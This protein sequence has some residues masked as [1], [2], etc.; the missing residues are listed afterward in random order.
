MFRLSSA[1]LRLLGRG[2]LILY[3]ALA[4][5]ILA[6]RYWALPHIDD[7]R[8]RIASQISTL[9]DINVS[10][11]PMQ[12]E[13]KG[14]NPS[15]AL[16][17][18][19]LT[20]HKGR[21]LLALPQV[22]AVL[23]WR[24]LFALSPL[25]LSLDAKGADLSL[26]RDRG[27]GYWLMGQ[28]VDVQAGREAKT[29]SSDTFIRWLAAQRNIV[30]RDAVLRWNDEM[31]GAPPLVLEGVTL[32]L[33]SEGSEHRLA[34]AAAPPPRLGDALDVRGTF[35]LSAD[36][37]GHYSLDAVDGQLYTHVENLRPL[38]WAPWF[39]LP[40]DLK[41]GR[42]SMQTWLRVEH[43]RVSHLTSDLRVDRGRWVVG[44]DTQIRARSLHLYLDGS[45][46]GY[47]Q[48]FP[49]PAGQGEADSSA[50]RT[51]AGLDY[52]LLA[53]GL[54]VDAP[55]LFDYPLAFDLIWA[56]GAVNKTSGAA[57]QL[58]ADRLQLVN[59]DMDATL[60]GTWREGGSG[61][62]GLI[63]LSGRF[64]RAMITAIDEYLPTTVNLDAREWMAKGLLDGEITDAD[65]VLQGDL[66][67]FPFA[68]QPSEGD[69]KVVGR[70]SGGVIDYLPPEGK[71]LGWPRLTDMR[72][73]VSLHRAD[74]RL[75]AEQASMW[76]ASGL[77][78]ELKDVHARIPNIEHDSV[79]TIQGQTTAK[80]QAY[81]A[82]MTHSPLGQMLDGAFDEARADG[83]WEV[84]LELSIPLLHS[85]D[86]TV[87]GSIHLSG[88]ALRLM[89]EMPVF[90]KVTGSLEFTDTA[91]STSALQAEFLG[92]P[93]TLGGGIGGAY[94]GLQFD[95]RAA[96]KALEAYAGVEGMRRLQG[97]VPY[98]ALLQRGKADALTI[99][100]TS[101]LQGL[102]VNLP[103]PLGK[104]AQQTLPLK[105]DWRPGDGGNMVLDIALGDETRATL[106]RREGRS[107]GP[108]FHAGSLGIGKRPA[109]LDSGLRLDI[110]YP[111]IDLDAWDTAITEFSTP[112]TQAGRD[113]AQQPERPLLPDVGELR[114]QAKQARV[115]G[116]SLDELTFTARR[117]Q[118]AQ[119]R[120]DI[121]SS[122]TAGTLIWREANGRVAGHVDAVFDRLS[123]GSET[124]D[125]QNEGDEG[126]HVD[127]DLDFPAVNLHVKNF[128][129]Y[130]RH[131]GEL[132][133]VGVNQERGRL[134]RLDELKL[135]SPHA[136]LAGSGL[137]RLRGAQRG[138]TLDAQATIG[139][140]GAYLEQIGFKDLA[141]QGK[142]TLQGHFEWRNM[143]WE[144]SK[145][146][147]NGKMEFKLEKGRLSTLNSQ[148]ARLLE[149]LSLQ[150]V[151]RLARL[152]FNPAGLT[153]EGFPYDILRGALKFEDG[154]MSTDDYRVIGPVGTIVLGGNVDLMKDTLDLRAVVI[155]NLDVSGAAIAAGIAINPIVGLGA[156]LTQWLLQAPLAKAMTVEYRI[157]GPW[158][159]PQ[160]QELATPARTGGSR[161]RS[162]SAPPVEH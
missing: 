128:R 135:V 112:L 150:S 40:Q 2:A 13:W 102:A 136:S 121:S 66:E 131:V 24:S 48:L 138:L 83:A 69:F 137:W 108:Y 38:G 54:N 157:S 105:V 46:A 74:L 143:P 119:W 17:D 11:G 126:L 10:L 59:K 20:D 56:Q 145:R 95:G 1:C 14:L 140:L 109:P 47:R 99:S 49:A 61:P 62:G 57:L 34:L 37:Q 144:F 146:D 26:R 12:A 80:A 33:A 125:T 101:S 104:T 6:V 27:G 156:F 111:S 70:Y 115:Q 147:L 65:L 113:S 89:P 151:Q 16:T 50:G 152:D 25:F 92:G 93:V 84:P 98:K 28:P 94:K 114:L 36:P 88:S 51:D 122:Q 153:K 91:I 117:P 132:S 142:G 118:P 79:L 160:I 9:L 87:R 107:N 90:T 31:R 110:L 60:Q 141:H 96:A 67:H 120:V 123:L 43:G 29:D 7:W 71:E 75:Y 86:S 4:L 68:E 53:D 73:T 130:G 19:R 52:R 32:R 3:F 55:G 149:L 106:L 23:S 139:D 30:F 133:L 8:P 15:F 44:L 42:I 148:S 116:L 85:R 159:H 63:D 35:R 103:A 78:I 154:L 76:P 41:S 127:E 5:S 72:G 161:D 81:L 22:D 134:W 77:P 39:D 100:A 64:K 158:E 97:T 155:P 82:L 58:Q 129:L 124:T 162:R 18:V 45:W 21:L